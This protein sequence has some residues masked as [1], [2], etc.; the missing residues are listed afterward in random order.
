MKQLLRWA[1]RS[2]PSLRQILVASSS[3]VIA[4]ATNVGL[5]LGAIG[6]LA[7][8]AHRPGLAAVGV[9]LVAIEL[10]AFLRSPLRFFER[11]SSH[12][13]GFA[14][15][16]QWRQ[17]LVAMIGRVD[18]R[19][20]QRMGNGELLE[21]ALRD[22]DELQNLWV[23]ALLPLG[24]TLIVT[25]LLDGVILVLPA[26]GSWA[27]VAYSFFILQAIGAGL[28]A[29]I[30][31]SEFRCDELRRQAA[32]EYRNAV[33]NI[34]AAAPTLILLHRADDLRRRLARVESALMRR[35]R[36]LDRLAGWSSL[37][38]LL[39]IA[40]SLSA[41]ITAPPTA[42]L[43][44]AVVG[45]AAFASGELTEQL[46]RALS[47]IVTV[48]AATYRLDALERAEPVG[49]PRGE[50]ALSVREV[51]G[52]LELPHD[53]SFDLDAG[54]RLAITGV[55]GAGKSTLLRIIAGLEVPLTGHVS[56]GV[57]R[58]AYVPAE[59]NLVRGWVRDVIALGVEPSPELS[60]QLTHLALPFTSTDRIG[61]LSRGE[62]ARVGV[63][64]ALAQRPQLVI[65]DE[66]TAGLDDAATKALLAEIAQSGASVLVASHDRR[67]IQWCD[68]VVEI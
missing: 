2:R 53:V 10:A 13:V 45:A 4:L 30:A 6:L 25:L 64:R 21:R 55:S 38:P 32:G 3:G 41:L 1:R 57:A 63:L 68:A 56:L 5:L 18:Y 11:M 61:E 22:T 58:V 7:A 31:R 27:G 37:V 49:W 33:V 36:T 43:W 24:N 51:S 14:A 44:L 20:L 60:A 12:E 15:V 9:A 34:E 67:V 54:Q 48:R 65:L 40:G 17:W 8:S 47:V 26:H 29:L 66:P 16:S 62:R 35:E 59:V 42:G 46:A 50:R 39:V 28:L 23:R 52:H 19:Q